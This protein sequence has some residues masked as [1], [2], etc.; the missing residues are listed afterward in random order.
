LVR[1]SPNA[2]PQWL[3]RS[4]PKTF[5]HTMGYHTKLAGGVAYRQPKIAASAKVEGH[6]KCENRKCRTM[7]KSRSG[8]CAT[9]RIWHFD[10]RDNDDEVE[11]D[12]SDTMMIMLIAS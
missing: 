8:K 10:T 6:L 1:Y 3:Q 12:D 9:V 7:K 5:P 11:D 4:T 2:A